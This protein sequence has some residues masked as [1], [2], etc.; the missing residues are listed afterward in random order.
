MLLCWCP[1]D[2]SPR[3]EPGPYSRN[4]L[5]TIRSDMILW[6]WSADCIPQVAI[7]IGSFSQSD[8]RAI[9]SAPYL[10]GVVTFVLFAVATP[11]K[12]GDLLFE[13]R[14][15]S[16]RLRESNQENMEPNSLLPIESW[17]KSFTG[18]FRTEITR[19]RLNEKH[20]TDD[21]YSWRHNGRCGDVIYVCRYES[22]M[23]SSVH[24]H[25]VVHDTTR[26][27][28]AMFDWYVYVVNVIEYIQTVNTRQHVLVNVSR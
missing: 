2:K 22:V 6:S 16:R 24:T 11:N 10:F 23:A 3:Q 19:S 5:L 8:I 12:Y 9:I 26:F 4:N 21:I 25:S 15:T 18:K 13:S 20:Q 1:G 28:H 7:R 14:V 17:N 27:G